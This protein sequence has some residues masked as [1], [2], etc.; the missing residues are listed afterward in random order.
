MFIRTWK[1][2]FSLA[3][4]CVTPLYASAHHAE[5]EGERPK[6]AV[7]LAGGGAKGAAHVGVLKALEEMQIP[8]DMITGTSM[9]SYFGGLYATGM[10][11]DEVEGFIYSVD[12]NKGYQDRV[13]RSQRRVRDK[14][15]E[16]RY[17]IRTDLGLT[18]RG[19]E[20]QTGV[21]Q[22]QNMLAIL[23][24]TTGN[25]G[26]FSSFDN[27]A[28]P[29]R[30]VATDILKLEEVVL[31][32]GY[33]VD[34]M[35]ASMS[36]PGALPPYELHGR[37]L[38][39]GG[40]TNNMPVDLARAMGA[41]IIIAVDISTNYKTRE[42]LTDLFSVA[43][44]LSNYMVRRSTQE[45]SA[46]LT[47][48]DFY[49]RPDVGTMETTEFDKMP[50]AYR[51]GYAIA[52]SF[53]EELQH[54]ALHGAEYQAYIDGKQAARA[55]L[56]YGD[57][58]VID[59]FRII[60]NTHYHYDV[61]SENLALEPG[62]KY[63]TSELE[64]KVSSLY[65]LDRFELVTYEY[66]DS[67]LG[68]ETVVEF[69]VEEKQWGPNY[70][71]FRFFL[72]D[73]FTNQS[74]YS[75]GVTTNFTGLSEFGA[76]LRT[77]LELGTDKLVEASW[78]SPTRGNR[79]FFHEIG[80]SYSNEKRL[81]PIEGL[82]EGAPT[83]DS[84]DSASQMSYHR[85]TGELAFGYQNELW[86]EFKIGLRYTDG[87]NELD[88]INNISD[89]N[90]K[91]TTGFVS[92][93]ADSLDNYSLPTRGNYVHIEYKVSHDSNDHTPDPI[94]PDEI[95]DDT[96]YE[97]YAKG[98]KAFTFDRHT[99]VGNVDFNFFDSKNETVSVDPQNLGGFLNLSG[100]PRNSLLGSNKF[101][102]SL[103]YRYRWF[104]NDF[105]LFS[106]P[107]YVGSSIEYG[108]VWSDPDFGFSDVPMYAAGSVF[109]GV[110]SP[111]GPIMLSY[112]RTEQSY[113]S[114]YL[115]IGSSF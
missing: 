110:D 50:E 59:S 37:M 83:L 91:R 18:W 100:T 82:T 101:F 7:V 98:M 48:K 30:A 109:A 67:Y 29:Y 39:D 92:Y 54:L 62:K 79:K 73:D 20:T 14:E 99:I 35:M 31:D 33:L 96:S 88:Y 108:G 44:Q 106:S 52:K 87:K 71:D 21:V 115:I 11:A 81:F 84:I 43:D 57:E 63:T 94:F 22:G 64:D 41:D 111:I 80:L 86:Q 32:K 34:A 49:M 4:A 10:S 16:D 103:V 93:R 6:V 51:E 5:F 66:Q 40:V 56:R 85:T 95:P 2:V 112:G 45:Q 69:E 15:V 9:G 53:E 28:I 75:I 12:W 61:L 105:G 76:E 17:Q 1:K 55:K 104:D 97:L 26:Y 107:F 8:V 68:D 90:Y 60:N 25:L 72:E 58:Q 114:F 113:E 78:Y 47:D 46:L 70:V 13:D 89:F 23:R 38:V 3:V 27:L 74:Q 36:V 42:E 77:N 102:T 65:V 19:V 24:E